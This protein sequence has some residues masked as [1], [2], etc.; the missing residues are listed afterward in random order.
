MPVLISWKVIKAGT[1]G[2]R[3]PDIETRREFDEDEAAHAI[4]WHWKCSGT[5]G[6]LVLRRRSGT[7]RLSMAKRH[8]KC[9][10]S[11]IFR[12]FCPAK[13]AMTLFFVVRI[14]CQT[15]CGTWW[16]PGTARHRMSTRRYIIF[17]TDGVAHGTNR[18]RRH[19]GTDGCWHWEE[20]VAHVAYLWQIDIAWAWPAR[21]SEDFEGWFRMDARLVL[22]GAWGEDFAAHGRYQA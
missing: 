22:Y 20:I 19:S 1:V 6:L 5:R 18:H 11:S 12:F 7:R 2:F 10:I 21:S 3:G 9:I 13:F 16:I 8:C 15:C 17:T 14:A 4:K